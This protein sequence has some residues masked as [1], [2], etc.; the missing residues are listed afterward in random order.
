MNDYVVVKSA[1]KRKPNRYAVKVLA[2]SKPVPVYE[3]TVAVFRNE[4]E[5]GRYAAWR[6]AELDAATEAVKEQA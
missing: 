6:Q 3:R 5:A 4:F 1:T 2:L